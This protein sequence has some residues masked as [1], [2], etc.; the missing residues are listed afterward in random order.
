MSSFEDVGRAISEYGLEIDR[1]IRSVWGRRTQ[2]ECTD[3][4][5]EKIFLKEWSR[6]A[7]SAPRANELAVLTRLHATSPGVGAAPVAFGPGL[8]EIEVGSSV[9]TASEF[10]SGQ[11]L[12]TGYS[13]EGIA[14]TFQVINRMHRHVDQTLPV[15]ADPIHSLA[16]EVITRWGANPVVRRSA[17]LLR[18]GAERLASLPTAAIHGD[19]NFSNVMLTVAGPRLVD[20]EF[21]RND[22]RLLDLA[23]LSFPSR[24][25]Q[26][27]AL[28]SVEALN[29]NKLIQLADTHFDPPVSQSER[30]MFPSAVILHLLRIFRD[31]TRQSPHSAALVLPALGTALARYV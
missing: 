9:L 16:R 17:G 5:G 28:Q 14:A 19:L 13:E 22:I 20:F 15:S 10:I 4:R 2:W 11:D 18:D 6:V 24:G 12:E 3:R 29:D 7:D 21:S 31:V 26:N 1:P 27:G 30:E 8:M 23:A 25:A